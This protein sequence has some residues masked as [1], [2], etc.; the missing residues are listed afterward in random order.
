MHQK[1]EKSFPIKSPDLLFFKGG[2]GL[3][4]VGVKERVCDA[5]RTAT[6]TTRQ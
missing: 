2:A 6:F 1:F 5:A 3:T 4:E